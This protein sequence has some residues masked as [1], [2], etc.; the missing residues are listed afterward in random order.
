MLITIIEFAFVTL[1]VKLVLAVAVI[2]ALFP[3][4]RRCPHCDAETLP[5]VSQ[6]GFVRLGRL[7]RVRCRWCPGCG[8]HYL[9]RYRSDD[10]ATVTSRT[11]EQPARPRG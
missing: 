8:D 7:V 4:D 3:S 9:A 6:R 1:G 5:L 10:A 11:T 2:Y